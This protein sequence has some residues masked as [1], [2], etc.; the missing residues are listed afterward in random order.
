M[1]PLCRLSLFVMCIAGVGMPGSA[2]AQMFPWAYGAGYTP[3]YTS[4]S[5]YYGTPYST[6]YAPGIGCSSCQS[7]VADCGC[8]PC[9]GGCSS[10]CASGNCSS[11]NC[12]TTTNLAPG[13]TLTPRPDPYNGSRSVEQRLEA[14]ERELRIVPPRNNRER[15][16]NSDPDG[17][18]PSTRP[19]GTGI[20]TTV[21]SRRPADTFESPV[22]GTTP[23]TDNTPF[24]ENQPAE[25]RNSLRPPLGDAESTGAHTDAGAP[26]PS[27]EPAQDKKKPAA[28]EPKDN[29]QTLRLDSRITS[30]A[31]SPRERLA[32][33]TAIEKPAVAVKKP[34]K[35]QVDA[36]PRDVKMA[37]Y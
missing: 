32:S 31:V 25:R 13:G 3:Y 22:P 34:A 4:Y 16:Y 27:K 15:T 26:I 33:S 5:G 7:Y 30:R 9:A 23:P 19:R 1:S 2:N 20:D 17:F 8:S 29:D 11:G 18:S 21:P 10:G 12:S 28:G 14:I 24:E 6:S 35:L 36:Q 37:R